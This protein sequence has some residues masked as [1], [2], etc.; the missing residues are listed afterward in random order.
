MLTAHPTEVQRKSTLDGQ[1]TIARLLA[2]RDRTFLTP[3]ELAENDEALR[4]VILT[5][6]QTRVI[7]SFQ[8]TVH[9]EIENGLAYYRYT[10]LSELPRVYAEME[11]LASRH[12]NADAPVAIVPFLRMGSW[13]GGDRDGNPYVTDQVMRHAMERH[14]AAAFQHYLSEVHQLG[15]E[16]SLSARLVNP[17]HALLELA[18]ASPDRAES[19][20]DEPYR[21]A[22]AGVYARLAA[23]AEE[24]GHTVPDR[25]PLGVAPPYR[26][27]R[28]FIHE[29]DIL[30]QSLESHGSRAIARGRLR[31]LRRAAEVFGFHLATLDMRQHSAVHEQVVAELFER[32][33]G[34]DGYPALDELERRRWLLS[35]IQSPRLLF[36]PPL[37][38]SEAAS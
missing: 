17:S 29:L 8:L 3:D 27:A 34:R 19:R 32:G 4:R 6:W 12:L 1:R 28:E 5:L 15:N 26:D 35:E 9:D 11:D 31:H 24:L 23:T 22:L 38:Y 30:I 7:R 18:S 2:E 10:F 21:R 25:H 37:E 14:S 20:A 16:L 33:E 13:I 36:S